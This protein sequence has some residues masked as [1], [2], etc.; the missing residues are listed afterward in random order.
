MR[1]RLGTFGGVSRVG[2]VF[3]E[4]GVEL[5]PELFDV[6][7]KRELHGS[8]RHWIG[9]RL[10]WENIILEIKKRKSRLVGRRRLLGRSYREFHSC[11]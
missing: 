11:S 7:V 6:G 8:P 9:L 4:E 2:Q 5:G 3:I 10:W 1:A